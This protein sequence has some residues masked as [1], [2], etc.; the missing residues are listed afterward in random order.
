[1]KRAQLNDPRIDD[2]TTSFF[3]KQD[4][5]WLQDGND[6]HPDDDDYGLFDRLINYGYDPIEH[7]R[8]G[9]DDDAGWT[10][11]AAYAGFVTPTS[12]VRNYST[13]SIA[14]GSATR[15][16][17]YRTLAGAPT[18]LKTRCRA[19]CW[20]TLDMGMMWDDG[21]DAGDNLGANNFFR[22]MVHVSAT[23]TNARL[24]TEYRLAAGAITTTDYLVSTVAKQ[25]GTGITMQATGTLW[26]AWSVFI[27]L[28]GEKTL[29]TT[30]LLIGT[31]GGAGLNFTPTRIGVYAQSP[32]GLAIVG[33]WDWYDE[34]IT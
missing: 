4:D 10:G 34:E 32:G 16:F 23:N 9:T 33:G 2:L 25:D 12:R 31:V 1:M 20:R 17:Y 19:Y 5:V 18:T 11:W 29:P 21:V 30:P 6:V 3:N 15:M 27:F 13:L 24:R 8:Y 7:W 26:T 14:H 28:E 22:Y